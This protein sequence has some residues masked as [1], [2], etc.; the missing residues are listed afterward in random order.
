MYKDLCDWSLT[1]ITKLKEPW[2][3][4][5]QSASRRRFIWNHQTP[6]V[7]S[8]LGVKTEP[9]LACFLPL[10]SCFVP[11]LT[12]SLVLKAP[13]ESII[14]AAALCNTQ[15]PIVCYL[16]SYARLVKKKNLKKEREAPLVALGW[17]MRAVEKAHWRGDKARIELISISGSTTH[18]RIWIDPVDAGRYVSVLSSPLSLEEEFH[19]Q[20]EE[21]II[22]IN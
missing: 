8:R 13:P 21:S 1:R 20:M 6:S 17:E 22:Q 2:T 15:E 10:T 16:Q 14:T 18:K 4:L 9:H 11:R 12:A 19:C 5:D 3:Y 7:F